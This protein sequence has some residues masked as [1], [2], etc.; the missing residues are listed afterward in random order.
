[1]PRILAIDWNDSQIRLA[2]ANAQAN[3]VTIENTA[4][5]SLTATENSAD[6]VV[7]RIADKLSELRWKVNECLTII[8]RSEVELRTVTVPPVPDNEL[9]EI[10]RFQSLREF[11]EINDDWPIDYLPVRQND[12]EI[13]VNAATIAPQ[14]VAQLQQAL[15]SIDLKMIGLVMRPTGTAT[16]VSLNAEFDGDILAVD[17][18][19]DSAELSVIGHDKNLR[20]MRS[21]RI[22]SKNR[23][24]ALV[25]EINRTLMA[26]R[27]QPDLDV[28]RVLIFGDQSRQEL[29]EQ[30]RAKINLEVESKN[31]FEWVSTG[32]KLTVPQTPERFAALIGAVCDFADSDHRTINFLD[33]RKAPDPPSRT[34]LYS[35][36]GF[37]AI[38]L[39]GA[40]VGSIWWKVSDLNGQIKQLQREIRDQKEAV[41]KAETR[42]AE[43]NTINAWV[44]S[45]VNWLKALERISEELPNANEIMLQDFKGIIE[46]SSGDARIELS[47]VAAD[48]EHLKTLEEKLANSTHR[49][50]PGETRTRD[51]AQFP[52]TF[53]EIVRV[54]NGA[55]RAQL[56]K[57]R[58][59]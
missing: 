56:N 18:L 55:P 57:N 27:N 42:V 46:A 9:P 19:D 31:P 45:D 1:M 58:R 52:L 26:A 21:V 22:P 43:V 5:L 49:L 2:L 16:L 12:H 36:L 44:K 25:S 29:I 20:L 37:A 33:P 47:G 14:R 3:S 53:K 7:K 40:L 28:R 10:V 38:L 30:I 48:G 34:K 41:E 50:E 17:D 15:E 51:D 13:T 39:V 54:D 59:R 32:S 23:G 8:G 6:E 24:P 11:S 4:E 35:L